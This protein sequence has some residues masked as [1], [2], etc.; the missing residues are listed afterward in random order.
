MVTLGSDRALFRPSTL[1]RECVTLSC[2]WIVR[3]ASRWC[4]GFLFKKRVFWGEKL[5]VISTRGGGLTHTDSWPLYSVA[6]PLSQTRLCV[7]RVQTLS[8]PC[9][10][11]TRVRRKVH[12]EKCV[13]FSL[14]HQIH[15]LLSSCVS[16]ESAVVPRESRLARFHGF[17]ARPCFE[18]AN[19]APTRGRNKA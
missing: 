15:F 16:C 8:M 18:S 19:P 2:Q 10:C 11:V 7:I 13:R 14:A 3:Q 6:R 5:G 12:K 9:F 1:K 4:A 17:T